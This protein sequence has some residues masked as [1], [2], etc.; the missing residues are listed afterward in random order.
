MSATP[1][2]PHAPVRLT[3]EQWITLDEEVGGE[4]VDGVL[5]EEEMTDWQHDAVLMWLAWALGGWLHQHGGH[6]AG[7]EAKY[8]L[9]PGRGRKPDLS[10]FLPESRP[11]PRRGAVRRAADVMIEIVTPTPRDERRDRIEKMDEYAAFGVRWYWIVDPELRLFEIYELLESGTYARVRGA[12]EGR[13]GDVPG[14]PGLELDLDAM[15]A[16]VDALSS[17]PE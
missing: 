15:W 17:E 4:L 11:P 16:R 13:L 5:V 9:R 8:L 14:F 6:I 7:S 1:S 2:Q 12:A 10:I 3:D